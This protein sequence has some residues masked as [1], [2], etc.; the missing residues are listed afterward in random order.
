MSKCS[1]CRQNEGLDTWKEKLATWLAWHIF[2]K[3]IKDERI[4]ANT[5]GFT[6]GYKMGR[7]HER[8]LRP[9]EQLIRSLTNDIPKV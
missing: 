7:E 2:P 9:L 6:D 3:T 1:E 5:T 4:G 8:E